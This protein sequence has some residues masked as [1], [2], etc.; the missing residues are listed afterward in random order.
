MLGLVFWAIHKAADP[1][2]W[3]GLWRAEAP[4]KEPAQGKPAAPAEQLDDEP[5]DDE[6]PAE[7]EDSG[8]YFPGVKPEY[9]EAVE[10]GLNRLR[11]EEAGEELQQVPKLLAVDPDS[12]Q[13]F[14]RAAV[15]Y[16]SATFQDPSKAP[17]DCTLYL[18]QKALLRQRS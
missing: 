8:R 4:Q 15:C 3:A 6:P 10:L 11:W 2:T 17:G 7:A 16:A 14:V 12:V 13:F 9:L 1:D 18:G 5:D